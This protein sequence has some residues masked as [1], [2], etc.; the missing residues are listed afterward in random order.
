MVI[1]RGISY[2]YTPKPTV[3]YQK[4]V[5][6]CFISSGGKFFGKDCR[7]KVLITIYVKDVKRKELRPIKRP[8]VDNVAKIILDS[9]NGIAFA[10]DVQIVDLI[11]SRI[12]G[13]ENKVFVSLK[14]Q[15]N[16]NFYQKPN[17][18]FQKQEL[19]SKT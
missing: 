17:D 7:V 16:R 4:K 1:R 6:Q 15:E 18:L 9:L 2:V 13:K 12:F 3:Q 14:A 11:V 5:A 10:D 8:D 19:L